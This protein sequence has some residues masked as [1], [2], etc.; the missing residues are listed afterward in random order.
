MSIKRRAIRRGATAGAMLAVL[1]APSVASGQAVVRTVIVDRRP[2]TDTNRVHRSRFADLT[3][4]PGITVGTAL[5]MGDLLWALDSSVLLEVECAPNARA[6]FR[7]SDGFRLVVLPPRPDVPCVVQLLAGGVDVR[8]DDSTEVNAGGIVLGSRGTQ[9]AVRLRRPPQGAVCDGVVY[10]DDLVVTPPGR[11]PITIKRSNGWTYDLATRQGK[12]GAVSAAMVRQSAAIATEFD[13]A[14]LSPGAAGAPEGRRQLAEQLL[15]LHVAVLTAPADQNV[16]S[17]LGRTQERFGIVD[18][19]AYNLKRAGVQKI[20]VARPPS[21]DAPV[22]PPP[23]APT[24][25]AAVRAERPQRA[26]VRAGDAAVIVEPAERAFELIRAGNHAAAVELLRPRVEAGQAK[27]RDF[28]ALAQAYL[29]LGDRV[30]ARRA[31]EQALGAP[32]AAAA[33]SANEAE[34][35]RAVLRGRQ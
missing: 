1:A 6:L 29:S 31:A 23:A 28:S 19:A 2:V 25:G 22:S 10:D 30:A 33:L 18:G 15:A 13:L 9:Y 11:D 16:R 14:R 17:Q 3:E 35:L 24:K 34:A 7:F 4:E 12:Q 27:A 21:P 5:E 26:A 32:D 8:A 20:E